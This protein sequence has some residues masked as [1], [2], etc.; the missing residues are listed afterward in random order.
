MTPLKGTVREK[1]PR[2][3]KRRGRGL[4]RDAPKGVK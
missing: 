2:G 1:I 3:S 4:F